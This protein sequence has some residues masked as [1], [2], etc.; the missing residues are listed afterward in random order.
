MNKER[1]TALS[2]GVIAIIITII[3]SPKLWA[4]TS[5]QNLI[6]DLRGG[7]LPRFRQPVVG[8]RRFGLFRSAGS[9]GRLS[10]AD[11][12]PHHSN[13]FAAGL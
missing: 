1:L 13:P 7:D 9:N 10:E 4:V 3:A 12:G 6:R 2:Y 8:L 11:N 5:G